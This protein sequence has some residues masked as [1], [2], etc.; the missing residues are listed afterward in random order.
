MK[1]EWEKSPEEYQDECA[2]A[3]I[4]VLLNTRDEYAAAIKVAQARVKAINDEIADRIGGYA[5]D[6]L[7]GEAGGYGTTRI[8]LGTTTIKAV[9]REVVKWDSDKLISLL[10][11]NGYDVSKVANITA[12]VNET[13]YK[14]IKKTDEKLS[15][16]L[17]KART[18]SP[19]PFT[20]TLETTDKN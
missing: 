5:A 1:A 19:G 11:Q 16:L 7:Q 15:S 2:A 20:F 8:T 6:K 12:K 10:V 9:R 13:D 14:A 17:D 3:S 18:T 4:D